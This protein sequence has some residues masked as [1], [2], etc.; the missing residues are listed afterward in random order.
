MNGVPLSDDSATLIISSST[1]DTMVL[2]S[3][4]STLNAT[5]VTRESAFPIITCT[6]S[7]D[8]GSEFSDCTQLVVLC[9]SFVL[10]GACVLVLPT[11]DV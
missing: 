11:C 1:D 4:T 5:S 7:S 3:V 2:L 8:V 6:A 10:V 9:K